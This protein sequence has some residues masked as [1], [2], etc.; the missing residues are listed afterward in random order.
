MRACVR[1]WTRGCA[2]AP[3]HSNEAGERDDWRAHTHHSASHTLAPRGKDAFLVLT[4]QVGLNP[5]YK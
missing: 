1:A 5:A 2:D 3:A 4:K